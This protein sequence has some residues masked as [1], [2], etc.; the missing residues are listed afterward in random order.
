MLLPPALGFSPHPPV[1]VYG[2]GLYGTIAAFL[3]SRSAC[4]V[5]YG[6]LRVTAGISVCGFAC[7]PSPLLAPVFPFPAHA[8]LLR[9]CSSDH[10]RYRNLNLLSIGYASQP[11]LR[12]R[13]TQGRSA[14]PWKPWIFG[15]EDSHLSLATHSGI[16]SS[17]HSTAPSGTASLRQQCS[18]TI[19]CGIL[20]FGVVFQPRTFSAQDLS[21]SELLRTL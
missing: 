11:L 5:T 9:P 12:P 8:F 1:S 13:L 18:S 20:C 17:W 2:T 15:R 16:L 4:F 10:I 19:P 3:G 6:S 21:T 14:L 7:I